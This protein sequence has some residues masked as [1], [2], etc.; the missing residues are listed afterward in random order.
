MLCV[1]I[2]CVNCLYIPFSLTKAILSSG[3]RNP[4]CNVIGFF[5]HYF[6]ITSFF[7]MFIMAI[8]QYMQ[9]VRI[10][11]SHISHF[12]VK[13]SCIGWFL[14][15]IFP[16]LVIVFGTHGGY[17]GEHR[18]WINSRLLLYLTLVVPI[19]VIILLN[20]ILFIFTIKSIF[21]HDPSINTNQSSRSKL[22]IGASMCCFASIG[23]CHFFPSY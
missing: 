2:L 7:W 14:P 10:F 23:H 12:F 16:F 17:I 8:I 9:F 18:C 1:S 22:Q 13:A 11:N 4:F 5:F 19:A 20:S 21:H 15:L 3:H 6:L